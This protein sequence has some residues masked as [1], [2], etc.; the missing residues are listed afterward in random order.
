MVKGEKREKK[1]IETLFQLA[2]EN[3]VAKNRWSPTDIYLSPDKVVGS[4][5]MLTQSLIRYP[6]YT[7]EFAS[8]KIAIVLSSIV[9]VHTYHVTKF[10]KKLGSTSSTRC[11]VKRYH[12]KFCSQSQITFICIS[13]TF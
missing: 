12:V 6:N 2:N 5:K 3:A 13:I 7:Y 4:A 11:K 10:Y 8:S 1:E 9:H